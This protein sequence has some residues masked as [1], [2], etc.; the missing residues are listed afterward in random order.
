MPG[1]CKFGS[2]AS[3]VEIAGHVEIDVY[4][5]VDVLMSSYCLSLHYYVCVAFIGGPQVRYNTTSQISSTIVT[6]A[7][8][9]FPVWN[10]Q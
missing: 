4:V 6:I 7:K 10:E 8:Q 9:T 3:V 2:C 1:K 5:I